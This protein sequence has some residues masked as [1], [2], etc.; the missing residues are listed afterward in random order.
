[1]ANERM[2][3]LLSESVSSMKGQAKFLA[4]LI[5]AVVVAIVSLVSLIMGQ[6][7][8]SIDD[9]ASQA[10]GAALASF[11]I[12]NGVPTFLFQ[13]SVGLY[14]LSLIIILILIVNQLDSNSDPIHVQNELGKAM[15]SSITK[16]AVVVAIGIILFSFVGGSVLADL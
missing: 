11:S 6:L 2:K 7:S 9:L 15:I 5:S 14:L 4:P 13:T 8:S 1:M 10:D 12:G 16:Y 3:D